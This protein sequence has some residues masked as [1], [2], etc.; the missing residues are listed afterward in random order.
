M[1]DKMAISAY[2]FGK[3]KT[4]AVLRPQVRYFQ[5]I[6]FSRFYFKYT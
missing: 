2:I 3:G 5:L 4:G 6:E 1:R